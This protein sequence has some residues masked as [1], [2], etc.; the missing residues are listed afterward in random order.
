MSSW[1]DSAFYL[2][3]KAAQLNSTAQNGKT[4]WNAY[5]TLQALTQAGFT[6]ETH[7]D[8]YGAYE[9]GVN[10][11]RTFDDET[12][13]NEKTALMNATAEQGRT[14]WTVDEVKSIFAQYGLSPVE[15]YLAYG[16]SEGLTPKS[17]SNTTFTGEVVLSG[18][19]FVD[20][21]LT[22][23]MPSWNQYYTKQGNTITY[24][25]NSPT[26]LPDSLSNVRNMDTTQQANTRIALQEASAV[27]GIVFTEVANAN[28]ADIVFGNANLQSGVAGV[29]YWQWQGSISNANLDTYVYIDNDSYRNL[30]SGTQYYEVL[31]HEIGHALGLKHPF[32]T[33]TTLPTEYDNTN[34]TLMSYTDIG[35]HSNYQ[36]L[37]TLAL[38]YLYGT[39]GLAGAQ[40]LA[41]AWSA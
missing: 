9:S 41:S 5:S 24:S 13:Y 26:T 25:F 11:S 39:D 29:T 3:Q 8:A 40:G 38:Q 35:I 28:S 33:P 21:L 15:H 12:Y 22:T 31:L 19:K 1:F 32:E 36:V 14:N 4:D 20:A 27:T 7:Y 16:K 34:Y 18:D 30:A 37:D 6:P 10:A 2:V 17:V 23:P